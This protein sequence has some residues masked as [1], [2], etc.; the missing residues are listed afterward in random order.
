[1]SV[2]LGFGFNVMYPELISVFDTKRSD[3]VPDSG[4]LSGL[5]YR[6]FSVTIYWSRIL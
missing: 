1:M 4:L 2:G 5:Y 6:R 3:A